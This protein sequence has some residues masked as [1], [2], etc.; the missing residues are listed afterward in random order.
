MGVV[1][2][3]TN[4]GSLMRLCKERCLTGLKKYVNGGRMRLFATFFRN[5]DHL[6]LCLISEQEAIPKFLTKRAGYCRT[7]I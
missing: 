3:S 6:P 2:A 7:D 5:S 4:I 1:I